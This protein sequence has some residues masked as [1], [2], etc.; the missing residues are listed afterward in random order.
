MKNFASFTTLT[1]LL[2]LRLACVP[3]LVPAQTGEHIG[4]ILV[5]TGASCAEE[6]D[7]QEVDGFT[8]Y[9]RH[10]LPINLSSR[11]RL[12]SSGLFSQYQ[13]ASLEDYRS[14]HGDVLSYS[15]L[16]MVE[17]F[18]EV[19]VA[20]LRPFISLESRSAPGQLN[21]KE[22]SRQ[23]LILRG[24]F[25]GESTS[26]GLKYKL[27]LQGKAAVSMAARDYYGDAAWF[28]PSSWS[29]NI[30]VN[31]KKLLSKAV[32]GDFNLRLGQGLSLWSGMSLGGFSSS[33]SFSRRPTGLS[34][35][36]SWSGI[37]GHRGVAADIRT[38]RFFIL[39][40]ISFPGLREKMEGSSK[41]S[42]R[43][44]PGGALGWGGRNGQ[45]GLQAWGTGERGTV[46]GDF[47][48]NIYGVDLFGEAALES[49][50]GCLAAVLGSSVSLGEGWRVSG[51]G[52]IYPRS[53][54]GAY[55][56]GVRSWTKTSD[57]RGVA[58][59]IERYGFQFTVDLGVKASDKTRKQVKL[60]AKLPL[61]LSPE[62]VLSLRFTERYRPYENYLVYRTGLRADVDWS[63]AGL[64]AR[65]GESD[66]DAWKGRFRLEGLLCKSLSGLT[67]V[68][69]GRKTSRFSSYLRATVFIVD[70]WDDRIYSYERDAP[71]NFS[72][73]AYYGRGLALS[74]IWGYKFRPFKT[75]TLRLYLKVSDVSYNFM[76]EAKPSVLEGKI[77]AVL[78][79]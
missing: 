64:S 28:P 33:S 38:G 65:Y 22:R 6:L 32:A 69:A 70:N 73:P 9:L 14:R 59:G 67:Y 27:S 8:R 60:F 17:G 30:T 45:V 26:Y 53:F 76:K 5:L 37:G 24:S 66:S 40:F 62:A 41:K 57:E 79:L 15:E 2:T 56:G 46:S 47:R 68:E 13:A 25:K 29:G 77:Q 39:P 78:A 20:A 48:W 71:G 31:G 42:V 55:S 35:S 58:V 51:V 52:R 49:P 43:I 44:M 75:K 7:E 12:L 50:S 1:L 18:D 10:P 3:V 36:Y 21:Q 54:E 63:S 61:Q 74:F 16:A 4:N 11:S 72:V 23:D 34:P 19:Y